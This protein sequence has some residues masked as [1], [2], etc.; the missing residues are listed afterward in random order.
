MKTFSAFPLV[1]KKPQYI[2][3][4][5]I[6]SVAV[7][8]FSTWLQN[9]KLLGFVLGS[10]ASI[11]TKTSLL[12][13]MVGS[14]ATN[15]TVFSASYTVAIAVLFGINIALVVY[16]FVRRKDFF[17]QSR[18][19]GGSIFGLVAGMLGVGCAACGTLVIAP[20]LALVGA[21]GLVIYLPFGGEEFGLIGVVVLMV[22]IYSISKKIM[23]PQVCETIEK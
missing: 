12:A 9:L 20:L 21:A 18:A 1:F 10:S 8:V 22:S 4:A 11:S 2:T 3:I 19:A 15:F 13:S 23:Q 6:V 17:Q 7:F 14:I 16:F 5:A